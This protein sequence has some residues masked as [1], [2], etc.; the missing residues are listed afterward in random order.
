[1]GGTVK[2]LS[3]RCRFFP[4]SFL[5]FLLFLLAFSAC[6]GSNSPTSPSGQSPNASGTYDGTLQF[7][8]NFYLAGYVPAKIVVA[9]SGSEVTFNLTIS[10][11]GVQV[12]LPTITGTIDSAGFFSKT[13][14]GDP[15]YDEICGSLSSYSSRLTF[16]GNTAQINESYSA[17]YCGIWSFSGKL[18][19]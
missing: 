11:D 6:G 5:F 2:A 19:R 12:R 7:N 8:N 14:S 17:E 10:I 9:Q 3:D 4:G 15:V 16:S 1:M 18:K 13:G